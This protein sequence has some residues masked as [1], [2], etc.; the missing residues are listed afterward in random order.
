MKRLLLLIP[1][2]LSGCGKPKQ[3]EKPTF[4]DYVNLCVVAKFTYDYEDREIITYNS[5]E[6]GTYY[7]SN[8]YY[9]IEFENDVYKTEYI[10]AVND[11]NE[12]VIKEIQK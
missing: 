6:L 3:E 11:K 8:V 10:S 12:L 2:L 1:L 4:I 7:L 9:R 5:M